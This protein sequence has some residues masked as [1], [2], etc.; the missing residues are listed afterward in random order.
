M[1]LG[2]K[3]ISISTQ[4]YYSSAYLIKP[5]QY[6]YSSRK[7]RTNLIA[8][9]QPISEVSVTCLIRSQWPQWN[10]VIPMFCV[11]KLF[12]HENCDS[13]VTL[14]SKYYFRVCVL[15]V[16]IRM[17]N[18]WIQGSV[19]TCRTRKLFRALCCS[20]EPTECFNNYF[21]LRIMERWNNF[22]GA[23]V[24]T[25]GYLESRWCSVDGE[26]HSRVF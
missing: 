11:S 1:Q 15:G 26:S 8:A 21:L 24:K 10:I 9:R 14:Q 18:I 3:N 20:S 2:L 12:I 6:N 16:I 4:Q 25:S 22:D 19:V 7:D 17:Y 13:L 5:N 23:T